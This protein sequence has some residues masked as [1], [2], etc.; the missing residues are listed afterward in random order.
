MPE[1]M[2]VFTQAGFA[3][4]L[5][6]KSELSETV[7]VS[8]FFPILMLTFL[9][10]VGLI[11]PADA[12]EKMGLQITVMLTVVIYIDVLQNSVPVYSALGQTPLLMMNFIVVT[13]MLTACLLITVYTLFFVHIQSSEGL[14]C[15]LTK[16]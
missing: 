12:G 13:V 7:K 3:M 15:Y 4:T 2:M 16:L 11:L 14:I 6:L 10:P 9:A 5:D 8:L 1:D